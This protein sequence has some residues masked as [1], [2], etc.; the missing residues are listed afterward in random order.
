MSWSITASVVAIELHKSVIFH[1]VVCAMHFRLLFIGFCFVLSHKQCSI[2]FEW[3]INAFI[4]FIIWSTMERKRL[5]Y[6]HIVNGAFCV[7]RK[8]RASARALESAQLPIQF[9]QFL[10]ICKVEI[11]ILRFRHLFF[12]ILVFCT[13][14]HLFSALFIVASAN[15]FCVADIHWESTLQMPTGSTDK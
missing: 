7:M 3:C 8:G 13:I 2:C 14:L 9:R 10:S 5:I 12:C 6:Q 4:S 1:F 11:M 15:W